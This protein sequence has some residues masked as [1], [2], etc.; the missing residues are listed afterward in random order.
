M[1][2]LQRYVFKK[3]LYNF[4]VITPIVVATVWLVMSVKYIFTIINNSVHFN[5]FLKLII[6]II[7][8]VLVFILP[9]CFCIVVLYTLHKMRNDNELIIMAT[10]GK[11]NFSIFSVILFFAIIL[12]ACLYYSNSTINPTVYKRLVH[13]NQQIQ[14]KLSLDLIKHGVFNNAGRSIVFI[15]GKSEHSVN[16][17]FISHQS[18]NNTAKDIVVAKNGIYQIKDNRMYI[19]LYNGFYQRIG[20]DNRPISSLSFQHMSYDITEFVKKYSDFKERVQDLTNTELHRLIKQTK[21]K[22]VKT[23]LLAE[24]NARYTSS[25]IPIMCALVIACFVVITNSRNIRNNANNAKCFAVSLALQLTIMAINN[26]AKKSIAMIFVNYLLILSMMIILGW[27]AF[28]KRRN[29]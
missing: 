17:V 10:S 20:A 14:G 27:I 12:S 22:K 6:L 16:N 23:S 7:P 21:N 11:S 29:A 15:E 25:I 1:Y 9:I 18:K 24:L 13:I 4:F 3:V 8:R 19:M 2:I 28:F 26:I 5:V